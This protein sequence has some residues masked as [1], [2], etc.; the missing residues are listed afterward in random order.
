MAAENTRRITHIIVAA[1]SGSR[2]GGNVPKQFRLLAGRPVVMHCIDALRSAY[3]DSDCI[4][5]LNPDAVELWKDLCRQFMFRSPG[6]VFGGATRWESV[7]NAL[8]WLETPGPHDVITV[9]DGARPLVSRQLIRD[10]VEACSEHSG[11]IPAIAVTDSVRMLSDDGPIALDRSRLRAV[12]TPQAFVAEELIDA[13]R[14]PY[15]ESFTDDA[16]VMTAAGYTDIV[17]TQGDPANIKIT[18]PLDIEVAELYM[19][20]T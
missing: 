6:I 2:F 11:A 14:H 16:S 3:E 4:I 8:V 15:Q 20:R 10:A 7:R 13:Y 12:Q 9:H 5:V 17:L 1:G 18:H 19:R